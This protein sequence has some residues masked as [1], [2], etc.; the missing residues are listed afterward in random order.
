MKYSAG[1][2]SK[3]VGNSTVPMVFPASFDIPAAAP[4]SA[5]ANTEDE[6]G[7]NP[8]QICLRPISSFCV[9][10]QDYN[11]SVPGIRFDAKNRLDARS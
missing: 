11:P 9:P 2:N 4:H 7:V 3:R 6:R 1:C 5:N 10:A 8:Q